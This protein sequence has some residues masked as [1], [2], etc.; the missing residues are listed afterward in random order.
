MRVLLLLLLLLLATSTS[1]LLLT[2]LSL[3]LFLSP[4][5]AANNNMWR[6]STDTLQVWSRVMVQQESLVGLGAI[7]GPGQWSFG[8][9]LELGVPGGGVLTWEES[10][11]HLAL[12]AV[13]SQPLFLGNDVRLGHV[14][15]RLL[16]ILLN[17]DML[18]VDLAVGETVILLISPLHLY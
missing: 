13:T 12:F 8:D 10:K 15:Q 4:W 1:A 2:S 18:M 9:C 16:D 5:C 17:K 14:Q 3:S 11:S 6:S 7:S